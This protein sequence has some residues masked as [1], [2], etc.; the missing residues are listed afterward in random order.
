MGQPVVGWIEHHA[1]RTPDRVALVD[2]HRARQLTHRELADRVRAPAWALAEGHGVRAGDRVAVLSRNDIRVVE[3]LY[4]GA[5]IGA[6]AVP[7]NW[8]LTTREL[9]D[10][11]REVARFPRASVLSGLPVDAAVQVG[12]REN[13]AH[14]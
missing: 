12:L 11:S 10:I 3:V 7:L 9:T 8:R 4:A 14:A 2:I 13:A 6:V 1:R 5:L